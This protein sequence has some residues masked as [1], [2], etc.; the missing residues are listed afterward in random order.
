MQ[1]IVT[2]TLITPVPRIAYC[3]LSAG[4]LLLMNKSDE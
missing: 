4:M 1:N 2:R 3:T